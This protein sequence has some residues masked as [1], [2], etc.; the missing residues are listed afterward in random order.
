MSTFA[1]STAMDTVWTRIQL[2]DERI[3]REEP[4]KVVKVDGAKGK[5]MILELVEEVYQIGRL[6]SPFMPETTKRIK[7]SALTNKKPENLFP[8]LT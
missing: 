6:L 1:F 2:C 5:Q 4:F 3:T 8:R 7:D